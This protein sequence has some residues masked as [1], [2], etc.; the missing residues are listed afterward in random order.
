MEQNKKTF[1]LRLNLFDSIVIAAALLVG[2]VLLWMQ[3]K[4]AA[5]TA[6]P[7]AQKIRFTVVLQK[8]VPGTGAQVETGD[9]LVDT[10]KNYEIGNVVSVETVPARDFAPDYEN[11]SYVLADVPDKE[12]VYIT[13][14]SSAVVTDEAVTVGTGYALR[15]GDWIYARGP[16]YLG[17]GKVYAIERGV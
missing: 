6:A 3:M 11:G 8:T 17:S 14:E 13:M 9:L 15:V 4:P 7:A 5:P 2:G 12:D 1:R 16:G 10:I